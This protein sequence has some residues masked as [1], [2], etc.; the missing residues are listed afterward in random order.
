MS[1][2]VLKQPYYLLDE[3]IQILGIVIQLQRSNCDKNAEE[4]RKYN[5]SNEER[6]PQGR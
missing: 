6:T 3:L 2:N 5:H 4:T 1:Y